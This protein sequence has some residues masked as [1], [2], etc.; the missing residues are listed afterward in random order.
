M[1]SSDQKAKLTQI[2][3]EG[4]N[5]LQEVEDLTAGLNDTIK[6]I[7]E[8]I[9]GRIINVTI[10]LQQIII[11]L[12][13]VLSKVQGTMTAGLFTLLGSYYTLKSLMGAIAQLIITILIGL[14]A[15]IAA[16]WVVPFTWGAAAANTAIFVAVIDWPTYIPPPTPTPPTTWSAP[17]LVENTAVVFEIVSILA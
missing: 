15:M 6:A 3:N 13:D 14:A 4:M 1:F 8:E 5:V 9:M 10:P 16:L 7:A 17:E 11:G 12:K 2:I